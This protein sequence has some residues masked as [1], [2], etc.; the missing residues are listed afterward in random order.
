MVPYDKLAAEDHPRVCGEHC[1][2]AWKHY[3]KDQIIIKHYTVTKYFNLDSY[4][5]NKHLRHNEDDNLWIIVYN[6]YD[7]VSIADLV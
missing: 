5:I 6:S 1:K 7:N 4:K 3:S 2:N